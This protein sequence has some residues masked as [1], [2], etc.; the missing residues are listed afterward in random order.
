M[1]EARQ[2]RFA[3]EHDSGVGGKHEIGK[4]RRRVDELDRGALLRS[5]SWMSVG[6]LPQIAAGALAQPCGS[7]QGLML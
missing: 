4:V 5:V 3:V 1:P 7:I 6:G 2:Q